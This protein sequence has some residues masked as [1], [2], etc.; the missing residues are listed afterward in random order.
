MVTQADV[1]KTVSYDQEE[2]IKNIL[3]L[4][5]PD[6]VIEVDPTFS[7]ENF[8]KNLPKPKY[9][10]D[11]NPQSTEV[12]QS[13]CRHLPHENESVTSIMFDPP[14]IVGMPAKNVDSSSII[15]NRFS[16]CFDI[17]DLWQLYHDALL[18]FYRILKPNGILIFKTQ[19]TVSSAKQYLSHVEIINYA[20]TLGFYPKDVFVLVAKNRI[21]GATHHKQQH[22]RKY[23][24]YFIIFVKQAS[25]VKYFGASKQ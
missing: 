8:Y 5:C 12:I 25:P 1:I 13:D 7:K 10:Y 11:I 16:R 4:Y 20:V 6:G 14:F 3:T 15:A 9:V 22:A 18:E 19:D 23:H 2:I 17:K 21:I 24:S